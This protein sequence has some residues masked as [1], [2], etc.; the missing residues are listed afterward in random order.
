MWVLL[1]TEVLWVAKLLLLVSN[2][3]R[4]GFCCL[5]LFAYNRGVLGCTLSIYYA[6]RWRVERSLG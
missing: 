2:P 3:S 1:G 5:G 4:Q 6:A